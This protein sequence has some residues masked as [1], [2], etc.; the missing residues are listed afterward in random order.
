MGYRSEQRILNRGI[1]NCLEA[2]KEM[3]NSL[4][5][6]EIQIKTSLRVHLIPVRMIKINV[7]GS[8]CRERC[9]VRGALLHWH[10]KVAQL[11]WKSVS[12]FL[13]KFGIDLLQDTVIR[14]Y[15]QRTLHSPT[16]TLTNYIHS[17]LIYNSQKLERTQMPFNRKVNTENVLHLHNEILVSC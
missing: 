15:I 2:L 12:W 5:I 4:A 1:L 11:L 13:W 6:R 3:F 10:C 8:S 7:S 9:G 17:S 16:R 14:A